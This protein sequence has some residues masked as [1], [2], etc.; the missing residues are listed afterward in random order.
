MATMYDIHAKL[1]SNLCQSFQSYLLTLPASHSMFF[2][3][4]LVPLQCLQ[5]TQNHDTVQAALVLSAPYDTYNN[6]S[7]S[8]APAKHLYHCI[9]FR[10]TWS[11]MLALMLIS[12]VTLVKLFGFSVP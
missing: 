10:G 11:Q 9:A 12:Y 3:T 6:V 5:I 8:I 2:Y 1:C 4:E 7:T